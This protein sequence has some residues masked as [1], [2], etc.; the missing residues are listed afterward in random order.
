M[1]NETEE[2]PGK[3][4]RKPNVEELRAILNREDDDAIVILPNGEVRAQSDAHLER[5]VA[6]Q[7]KKDD[8]PENVQDNSKSWIAWKRE[9]ERIQAERD[10]LATRVDTMREALDGLKDRIENAQVFVIRGAMPMREEDRRLTHNQVMTMLNGMM[11]EILN[12]AAIAKAEGR[13]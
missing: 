10:V 13:A 3:W 7:K 8:T 5:A 1:P 9:A 12:C 11:Q 2:V 6:A 4:S